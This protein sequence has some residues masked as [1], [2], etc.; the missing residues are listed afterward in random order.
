MA[1]GGAFEVDMTPELWQRLKPIY[2]AAIDTTGDARSRLIAEACGNDKTLRETLESLLASNDAKTATIDQ[3][4]IDL[5]SLFAFPRAFAD[6]E[7]I[8]GRFKI[9]RHVGTGG[10]G[11]VYE[12]TDLQLGRVALKT[13]RPGVTESQEQ[14][15][16]FR[17]EVQLARKVS[18]PHVC[19]IHELHLMD[20]TADGLQRAFLTM[21]FLEGKTLA[22]TIASGPLSWREAK[23]IALEIC[24]GLNSIHEAGVIHRDLKGRNIMLA[25]RNGITSA[26]LMDFGI[27]REQPHSA[28]NALTAITG[29][30]EVLG[31]P[32]Y[33]APEQF[34]DHGVSPATDVYALGI[35][36]Y[37]SLTGRYPFA[38]RRTKEDRAL[39]GS[40]PQSRASALQPGVPRWV[41]QVIVKCLNHDPSQRY[42]SARELEL[43]LRRGPFLSQLRQ[44]LA[45]GVTGAIAVA[46]ILSAIS[47]NAPMRERFKGI[48]FSSNRKHIAV[49]PPDFPDDDPKAQALGDGLMDDLAGRLSNLGSAN[50]TLWVVPASEVRSRK[51]TDPAAALREFGATIVVKSSFERKGSVTRLR[52]TLIDPKKTREIGFADVETQPEDLIALQEE[53]VTRLSRLMNLATTHDATSDTAVPAAGAA[54]EQYLSAIGYL[55]RYDRPGELDK[56]IDALLSAVRTDPYS[57]L[58]FAHLCQAYTLKFHIESKPELIQT[59]LGY[60]KSAARLSKN[61]PFTYV[62]L[63]NI[64]EITG[65]HPLASEE[66]QKA[67]DLDPRDPNAFIGMAASYRAA[68]QNSKA[69]AAYIMAA[70]LRPDDWNGYNYLGKFYDKLGRSHEAVVQFQKALK[71]TPDNAFVYCNL[72]GAYLNSGDPKLLGAA[73][74]ALRKSIVL[75]PTY[76]AFTNLGYLYG[77][78]KRFA[79]S[80]AAS[81]KA[82]QLNGEDYD[83]WNNL[84]QGYEALGEEGKA[85]ISRK[86]AIRLAERRVAMNNRDAEAHATLAALVAKDGTREAA[87]SHIQTSLALAPRDQ[88]VLSEIADAYEVLGDRK[89][90]I[91]YLNLAIQNGY[92]LDQLPADSTLERIAAD[93][94]FRP[95]DK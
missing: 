40:K 79:E 37:E 74:V 1:E 65:E 16:R 2:E 72:G 13:I 87:L 26:I 15:S 59:A 69:E 64:H 84:T 38:R 12:A 27:A 71:L 35:V 28:G 29:A 54:Y 60:C 18:S 14:L 19:R 95:R 49:L 91:R 10:M 90:G 51:V 50:P 4:I 77:I 11:E 70:Q 47:L 61:I 75:A 24:M 78:E 83:V 92:P 6:G 53:A 86:Q 55:Q 89:L 80:V 85:S 42:Q 93:P 52:L 48:F 23:K 20:N 58:A 21:E 63:A 8:Q 68:G 39:A 41:D 81:E 36:L 66:Y 46:L 76:Q 45:V 88:Y 9:L 5:R 3:P 44:R 67:I 56:A 82:L 57:A 62:A 25:S 94:D 7:L 33:M 34:D 43:V 32:N 31:T 17:R 22:D 73:E 30:D